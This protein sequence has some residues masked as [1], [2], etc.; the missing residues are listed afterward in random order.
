M[1]GPDASTYPPDGLG[2]ADSL[3]LLL[4]DADREGD[5]LELDDSLRLGLRESEADALP[6][7][8]SLREPDLLADPLLLSL[9][10]SE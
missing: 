1:D 5:R 6:D 7:R 10:E 3:V 8:L 9:A 2:E 4:A